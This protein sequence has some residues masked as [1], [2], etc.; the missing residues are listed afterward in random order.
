[1]PITSTSHSSGSLSIVCDRDHGFG[2]VSGIQSLTGGTNL[3]T[4]SGSAEFYYNVRAEGGTG[5]GLTLDVTVAA[6]ST[7]SAVTLN[8]P[9][10]GYNVN[11]LLTIRGVT[12][13]TSGNDCTI[14]VAAIANPVGD[15]VQIVGVGSE[16]Y[17]GTRRIQSITNSTTFTVEGSAGGP[18]SGGY[19]YHVGVTT[20]VTALDYS[21]ES[22]I[23]TVTLSSDIGLRRGD[24]IVISGSDAFYNGTHFIT[25]KVS[26]TQ[27]FVDFGKNS[28]KPSFTASSVNA[29]AEGINLRG[30]GRGIPIY[31]GH[32][33][34]LSSGI[35]T[36]S[37]SFTIPTADRGNLRRG[38]FLQ[39]DDE[40]V[41]VSNSNITTIIRGVMG[42]NADE[43]VVN[44]AVRKIKVLPIES[45]R[46]SI[47]RASGHTF[48]YV[49]FGSR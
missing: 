33:S 16:A 20:T 14:G 4:N 28:T 29:H 21:K 49:G 18:S 46:Y 12:H 2:G 43:H 40:I 23:G 39:I 17:D 19:V 26:G 3:G 25:D 32:T 47:L 5:R 27:L 22:G 38:D 10:S 35:S 24:R 1:M 42:T 6:S 7:I 34:L 11:D 8:N 15:A 44:A 45:R 37:T 31:G 9:G 48:E 41:M 36:T 30:D 13:H